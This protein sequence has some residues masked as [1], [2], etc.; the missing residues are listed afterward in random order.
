[1]RLAAFTGRV[2]DSRPVVPESEIGRLR[3]CAREFIDAANAT[4]TISRTLP[5]VRAL[6]ARLLP[7]WKAWADMI[8]RYDNKPDPS[9]VQA[10]HQPMRVGRV[11]WD[12]IAAALPRCPLKD[13]ENVTRD[14]VLALSVP[15]AMG[16]LYLMRPHA[17][18][19][20][21]AALQSWL[22]RT[23][24]GDDIPASF[25]R[26]PLPAVFLKLG[27]EL[28]KGLDTDFWSYAG[29]P[30][31]TQGVLSVRDARRWRPRTGVLRDGGGAAEDGYV[32]V[33]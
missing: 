10:S 8:S 12:M 25:F 5:P 13:P 11:A 23:D 27:P 20:P 26:L 22:A 9:R 1:M 30:C 7:A 15:T 31:T 33:A 2:D 16:A 6:Q 18:L 17:V 19:E 21:T 28:L 14:T 24:V 3:Q 29:H 32:S 4:Q